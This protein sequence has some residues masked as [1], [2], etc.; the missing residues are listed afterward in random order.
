MRH[1]QS[2]RKLNRTSSHRKS[3]FK[4]MAQALLKHE[5][6]V[7]TLPKAKELKRVVEKLITLGKKGNL[8]S[9]RLA[10]NQIRDKDMVSKLFEN[11]ASRYSDRKG[12]YTRVLKAGFRYGDSAPM[13]VIELVDRDENA[14]GAGELNAPKK[15]VQEETAA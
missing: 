1:R 9:R 3:L 6:I 11:L 10:F 8:H 2:G 12:G 7:T 4:N 5:Q 14:K 15:E 13:A